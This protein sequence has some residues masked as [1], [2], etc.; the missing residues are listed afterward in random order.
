MDS[1]DN[2]ATTSMQA[3]EFKWTQKSDVARSCSR[4]PNLL[5]SNKHSSEAALFGIII[6]CQ[7]SPG[8]AIFACFTPPVISLFLTVINSYF[9]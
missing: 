3:E 4:P 7:S 1:D 8:P 9:G 2:Q 6:S 5:L